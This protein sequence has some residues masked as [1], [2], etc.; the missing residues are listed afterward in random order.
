M[1]VKKLCSLPPP[2]EN[3]G[4]RRARRGM[5]AQRLRAEVVFKVTSVH[6]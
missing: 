1:V 3:K 5:A 6:G 4:E 2:R